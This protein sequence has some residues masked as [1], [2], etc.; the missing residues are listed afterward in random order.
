MGTGQL[1]SPGLVSTCCPPCWY[2][3]PFLF[4][5]HNASVHMVLCV[6]G[7]TSQR[8]RKPLTK[9]SGIEFPGLLQVGFVILE[10][11]VAG[12]GVVLIRSEQMLGAGMGGNQVC[13]WS[14]AVFLNHGCTLEHHSTANT[15]LWLGWSSSPTLPP[16]L[17]MKFKSF[18]GGDFRPIIQSTQLLNS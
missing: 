17:P 15:L 7:R 14:R 16:P 10:L 18:H 4:H 5:S 8:G 3:P 12:K 11:W 1:C 9:F 2:P 13:S 6:A